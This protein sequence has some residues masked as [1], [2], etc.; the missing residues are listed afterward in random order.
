MRPVGWKKKK[1]KKPDPWKQRSG[2]GTP[3]WMTNRTALNF[4][5][6]ALVTM[7]GVL[8]C[9]TSISVDDYDRSCVVDTDC[10][11]VVEGEKC[12]I[13]RCS[14]PF[15][16]I[17]TAEVEQ[18]KS[19]L[20]SLV[21]PNPLNDFGPVCACEGSVAVCESGVCVGASEPDVTEGSVDG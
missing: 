6:I 9:S 2:S 3:L 19:D 13:E 5:G 7:N 14:C 11:I 10:A 18:Y 16:A 1:K 21:C 15:T 4:L 17:N 12:L 20:D 8:G